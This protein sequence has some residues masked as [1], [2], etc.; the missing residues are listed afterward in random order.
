MKT[1]L[2]LLTFFFVFVLCLLITVPVF[3]QTPQPGTGTT[4]EGDKLIIANTF[5]LE[6][7]DV[8]NG[9]LVVI[10]STVT[11]AETAQLNGDVVIVGGTLTTEGTVTGNM[12]I[13]GGA[14]TLDDTAAVN[15]DIVSTGATLKQSPLASVSGSITEQTPSEWNFD[16]KNTVGFPFQ[17]GSAYLTQFLT[18]CL[19]A[20][21][22]AVL[23]VIIGLFLPAQTKR[24]SDTIVKEPLVT[25]GVGLLTVFCA[26]IAM[27][28]ISITIILIPITVLAAIVL[29]LAVLYGWIAV[30]NEIG[31]RIGR[32]FHAEWPVPVSSGIGVLLIS[33]VVGT[34][35]LLPCLGWIVGFIIII[36]GLGAVVSSRF[37]SSK[38][39]NK[40]AQAVLPIAPMSAAPVTQVEPIATPAQ[41]AATI[42]SNTP[43][44]KTTV[45]K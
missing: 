19:E 13:I 25:G 42:E 8:L 12:V 40:L 4:Y 2:R 35:N 7:G 3:A 23:A 11:I 31:E 45:Q 20:L 32:L 16:D 24:V 6:N 34:M 1:N 37:G 28:L 30:G 9:N 27:V 10:G 14:V 15:G 44:K 39:A 22:L 21:G 33:L 18:A 26:P 29:S 41:P 17:T 43:K 5:R 38:Y 36:L